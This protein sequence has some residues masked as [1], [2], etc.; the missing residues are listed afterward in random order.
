M[1]VSAIQRLRDQADRQKAGWH[2]FRDSQ[3]K[4]WGRTS[5][6]GSSVTH[7]ST[8][9]C[10]NPF[11]EPF[12]WRL[13]RQTA[14]MLARPWSRQVAWFAR[15]WLRLFGRRDSAHSV[16][17]HEP[18]VAIGQTY[19]RPGVWWPRVVTMRYVAQTPGRYPA[20]AGAPRL[21]AWRERRAGLFEGLRVHAKMRLP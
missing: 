10:S 6:L 20:I 3:D 13:S 21:M 15:L 17:A 19:I 9:S 4:V 1:T 5:E 7:G 8:W 16:L 18:P 12:E 2:R 11:N 14:V